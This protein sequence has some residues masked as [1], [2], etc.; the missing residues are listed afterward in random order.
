M[1]LYKNVAY[2]DGVSRLPNPF[3]ADIVRGMSDRGMF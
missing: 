2:Q 3:Q 1:E